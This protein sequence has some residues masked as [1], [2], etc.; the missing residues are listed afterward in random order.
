MSQEP[1]EDAGLLDLS[2]AMLA[3]LADAEALAAAKG[4]ADA[5]L[6]ALGDDAAD[7]DE[8][9]LFA[10]MGDEHA[11]EPADPASLGAGQAA[12]ADSHARADD[13]P[14]DAEKEALRA[15]SERVRRIASGGELELLRN[16]VKHLRER[17]KD[18]EERAVRAERQLEV[19][20]NDLKST[21]KRFS[22]VSERED[23]QA[24]RIERLLL[25]LPQNTKTEVLSQFL[26]ALDTTDTVL[27]S[28]LADTELS[29]AVRDALE[30]LDADWQRVLTGLQ[31]KAFDAIGQAF[32]P[33]V[34]HAIS[35]V[36]SAEIPPGTC[37]RQV[38]RGYLF[39]HRLL[40][41]AQ[42]VVAKAPQ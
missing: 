4:G 15:A 5:G 10:G 20:R 39:E 27:K 31:I 11:D 26:P 3:A 36:E 7:A 22:R 8:V 40:R 19:A 18:E 42:V 30:V 32:D 37:V 21:R 6:S 35:E 1:T 14:I 23:E 29:P 33:V 12:S 16:Q 38:G 28:A 17:V 34:H 9:D 13:P 25:E 24:A 41:S 2:T